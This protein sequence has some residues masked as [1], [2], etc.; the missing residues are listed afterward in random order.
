MISFRNQSE[1]VSCLCL[2]GKVIVVCL[3][4]ETRTKEDE[5][6]AASYKLDGTKFTKRGPSTAIGTVR[7]DKI[8]KGTSS[9]ATATNRSLTC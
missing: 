1:L 3:Q 5:T 6:P 4:V 8:C 2:P 7:G 9:N